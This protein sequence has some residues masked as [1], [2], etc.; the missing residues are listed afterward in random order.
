MTEEYVWRIYLVAA[1]FCI[2]AWIWKIISRLE[3][4]EKLRILRS[5]KFYLQVDGQWKN[6]VIYQINE[7]LES[8]GAVVV[9]VPE[10]ADFHLVGSFITTHPCLHD[11]ALDLTVSDGNGTWIGQYQK[12]HNEY[13][14]GSHTIRR[15][16]QHLPITLAIIVMT[17]SK[18]NPQ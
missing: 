1:M 4:E 10:D 17:A 13:N 3:Q 14:N 5:K 18:S 6:S 12:R 8:C 15:L 2:F 7:A 9:N 11:Y 16:I